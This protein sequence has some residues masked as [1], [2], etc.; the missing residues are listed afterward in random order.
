MWEEYRYIEVS[1]HFKPS[2]L[3]K[4][5]DK[6]PNGSIE[7]SK[8][9]RI[10]ID[11]LKEWQD[12]NPNK[13]AYFRTVQ[14]FELPN[15]KPGETH[16]CPLY[17]DLDADNPRDALR[18]TRLIVDYFLK[19][20]E[21][22]PQVWFSGNKGF[23]VQVQGL[24]FGAEPHSRLSY[25]WRHFLNRLDSKLGLQTTDKAVYSVPRMWRIGNTKHPKSGLYKTR[26]NLTEL[27]RGID[28]IRSVCDKPRRLP[29][30]G[31]PASASRELS[32]LYQQA[33]KSYE[34]S[35]KIPVVDA[36]EILELTKDTPPC[37]EYL[38]DNG[39]AELGTK[40]RADM[41]L[42]GYYKDSG[43]DIKIALNI[44][45]DW[46]E[47][48]PASLTH[49]HN[50][51]Q[52][53]SQSLRVVRTVYASEKYH[54]S[55][56][57][58]LNCGMKIDCTD[59]PVKKSQA[60]QVDLWSYSKAE[61]LGKRVVLE[62]DAI[63]KD[64]KVL[65]PPSKVK[66]TCTGYNT[67]SAICGR[68]SLGEFLDAETGEHY[69][70][71]VFNSKNPQTVDLVSAGSEFVSHLI[72]RIFG[73]T[74]RCYSFKFEIEWGNAQTIHLAT[75]VSTDFKVEEE[76]TRVRAIYL[77]H[78][79][80]LNK[81]YKLSGYVWS[82]PRTK[83]AVFLIDDAQ[84]LQS[85]LATF[86]LSKDELNE[87][88]IF[89][90]APGQS[91]IEKVKELHAAFTNDFIYIF[92]RELLVL[93]IDMVYHSA[94]WINFQKK[95]VKGWL[96]ILVVG[97][98]GQGKSEVAEMLMSYYGLGTLAAGETTSRTGLLYTIQMVKGEEAWVAFGLLP[99]A[100]GH[101][102]VVDEVHG[103]KA[104]DF[105][106]FTVVRSKGIVDVKRAAYGKA[107]AETRLISIAN[108]RP[109]QSMSSYG[110]PVQVIIDIPPF[111]ALEDVRRFDYAVGVRAGDVS[112]EVINRD[113][114]LLSNTEHPYTQKLC[115]NLILWVWTR[116]PEQIIISRQ[117]ERDILLFA[118]KMGQEYVPDIPLVEAADIRNKL[119]RLAT[120]FAGRTYNTSD[121]IN[122]EVEPKH[123]EAAYNML[124]DLYS[125]PGLD[126]FGFSD[127]RSKLLYEEDELVILN[128][129]FKELFPDWDT[130]SRWL[131]ANSSFNKTMVGIGLNLS[132]AEIDRILGWLSES[133]F[134][135]MAGDGK[136]RKTPT[137][138]D[139]LHSLFPVR[140]DKHLTAEELL[141][142]GATEAALKEM[143]D[144]PDDF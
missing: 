102:V 51:T 74:D 81:S 135:L 121:G 85:S 133:Q 45:G 79:L 29:F 125:A 8:W 106:E 114:Y 103:M 70:T 116:R 111:K 6:K 57:S 21:I 48:I 1:Y 24:V 11:K 19:G 104:A 13:A 54:F 69:R 92:G 101:L 52:R 83:A 27:S 4:F 98:T 87:L 60:R 64:Q 66:G 78:G 73:V 67:E 122:L 132:R 86:N 72:K 143:E 38:L 137:G 94:R 89:R 28:Y 90:P 77:G 31:E 97:D 117:T 129:Q 36:K 68:C 14:T 130:I 127:D 35:Q 39:L 138:R 82:H 18:D 123:A 2:N 17:I 120:A 108:A 119:I 46:A 126:Y 113:V 95:R 53:L 88:S 139:F 7:S 16:Y 75:T 65:I 84:P 15:S 109:G 56:G 49:V 55:C 91:V 76:I 63:G 80:L 131:L 32:R 44:M 40:N 93:A 3:S 112:E 9:A 115:K 33:K 34:D 142:E 26:L 42:A 47:S 30:D 141:E 25:H 58:M 41:A 140:A 10:H 5:D 23:H 20:F 22:E 62:A 144:K 59:C 110:Y 71:I 12:A 61:N 107:A 99:R 100:S 43:T 118:L 134:I 96:D 124:Y 50:P 37:V 136:Y 128:D 105:R